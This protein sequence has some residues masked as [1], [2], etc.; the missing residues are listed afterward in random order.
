MCC[1]HVTLTADQIMNGAL[2]ISQGTG[3]E[4]R[5]QDTLALKSV[6]METQV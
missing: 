6:S 2:G 4:C 1:G 3:D 5:Q